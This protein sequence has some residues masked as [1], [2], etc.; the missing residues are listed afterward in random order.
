MP[1]AA[2]VAATRCQ[3]VTSPNRVKVRHD[4]IA[5]IRVQ[6]F[7]EHAR[8]VEIIADLGPASSTQPPGARRRDE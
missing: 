2:T 3:P 8:P 4:A 7:I 5:G 1:D 6:C